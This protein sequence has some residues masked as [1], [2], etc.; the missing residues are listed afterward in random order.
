MKAV[1]AAKTVSMDRGHT[2]S[3]SHG[4]CA[5]YYDDY[6]KTLARNAAEDVSRKLHETYLVTPHEFQPTP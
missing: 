5:H 3:R 6:N 1:V 2:R 4:T